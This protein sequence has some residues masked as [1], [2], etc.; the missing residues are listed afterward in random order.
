MT[1][2]SPHC[3]FSTAFE[4]LKEQLACPACYGELR[5]ERSAT[6]QVSELA[7][8]QVSGVLDGL[9]CVRCGVLYPIVD[10]I[11]VLTPQAEEQR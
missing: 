9:V 2:D 1:A 11:P 4:A 7:S 3:E 10:G 5:L 6:R 8:Q